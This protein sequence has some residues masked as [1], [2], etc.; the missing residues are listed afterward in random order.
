MKEFNSFLKNLALSE[1]ALFFLS[2]TY[3][4]FTKGLSS[5]TFSFIL[6]FSVMAFD[7]FL[8]ARFSMRVPQQ[9]MAGYFPR[10]GF[11]WRFLAVGL[12]LFGVSLFTQVNFF[13]I[14]S[15][16][17]AANLGLFVA[18]IISR[19]EWRKWNTEA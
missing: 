17:V 11:F 18:V 3:L 7:L 15:A 6:G 12:I 2:L 16:V 14:I 13:A 5:F 1:G 4:L 9:V 10:S 8:L 19:K